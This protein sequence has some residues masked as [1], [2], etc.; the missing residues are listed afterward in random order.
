MEKADPD[1]EAAV[2]TG[3]NVST[4]N[5]DAQLNTSAALHRHSNTVGN[6]LIAPQEEE[7]TTWK[8]RLVDRAW[9]FKFCK[10]DELNRKLNQ[11]I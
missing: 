8:D 3:P 6:H 7:T 5:K 1:Q 2:A 9:W 10:N 11:K 4:I